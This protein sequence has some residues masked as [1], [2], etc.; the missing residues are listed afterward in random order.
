MGGGGRAALQLGQD[1]A[2]ID[3]L[4]WQA[5]R[6]L[7]RLDPDTRRA[8]QGMVGRQAGGDSATKLRRLLQ[9]MDPRTRRHLEQ[10]LGV[11]LD[12]RLLSSIDPRV[13]NRL[14]AYLQRLPY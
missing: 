12:P 5:K 4:V 2:D 8:V 1:M 3:N 6:A 10:Q 11:R 9:N 14:A 7:Q 13:V